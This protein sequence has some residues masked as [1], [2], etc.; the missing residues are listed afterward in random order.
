MHSRYPNSLEVLETAV[1]PLYEP[2][3]DKSPADQS[4]ELGRI[5]PGFEVLLE[6]VIVYCDL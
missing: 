3:N 2:R 4:Q 5:K 1:R 6:E